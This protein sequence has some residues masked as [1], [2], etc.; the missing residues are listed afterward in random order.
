MTDDQFTLA[1]ETCELP[2]EE[3]HHRGHLRLAWIY[4]RRY[5]TPEAGARIAESIR[6]FAAHH[7]KADRYHQTMTQAW[8][9]LM[10]AASAGV[11]EWASFEDVVAAF[12]DLLDK[13][14]LRRYYSG[15]VLESEAA[16]SSFVQPDLAALPLP[17]SPRL[18]RAH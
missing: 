13:S 1:F 12:P 3:F 8:L 14:V 17:G 7:G 18:L 4:L 16:R 11:A 15:L 5:G 9:T 2:G 6:R 10:E